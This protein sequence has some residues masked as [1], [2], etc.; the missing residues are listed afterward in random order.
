MGQYFFAQ[1]AGQ[2][3]VSL[4]SGILYLLILKTSHALI[5]FSQH[6]KLLPIELYN[7]LPGTDYFCTL[8]NVWLIYC[9]LPWRKFFP[10]DELIHQN[11][12]DQQFYLIYNNYSITALSL[13]IMSPQMYVLMHW[14]MYWMLNLNISWIFLHAKVK[15]PLHWTL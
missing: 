12:T 10:S 14:C 6:W 7:W 9:W 13:Y 1:A 8:V 2:I 4:S 3:H 11:S 15:S 5:L